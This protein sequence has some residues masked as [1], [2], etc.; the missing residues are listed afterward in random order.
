[1]VAQAGRSRN[2]E[3]TDIKGQE[4]AK[5]ALQIAATGGHNLLLL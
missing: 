5:R 4:T 1:M 3:L 2:P